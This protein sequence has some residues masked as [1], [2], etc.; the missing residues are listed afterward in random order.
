VVAANREPG[1]L[2]SSLGIRDYS[3]DSGATAVGVQPEF[4]LLPEG[5]R[6]SIKATGSESEL[7]V[8]TLRVSDSW[9]VVILVPENSVS[10]VK[11]GQAVAISVPLAG[12]TGLRGEMEE[13]LPTP[14]STAQ[15]VAYQA[16]VTVLGHQARAPLSGMSANVDLDS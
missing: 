15:G 8:I 4:S 9:E 5:P 16:V 3:S 11:A 13:V 14:E 10:A 2:V 1:E 7:P 12:I 6:S